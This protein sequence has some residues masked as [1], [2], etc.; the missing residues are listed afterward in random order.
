MKIEKYM[1]SNFGNWPVFFI[2]FSFRKIMDIAKTYMN[3]PI[4]IDSTAN[5]AL[6]LKKIIDEKKSRLL[7]TKDGK[8][9][10]I[11]S[12]KDLGLF[13]FS[14]NTER[15]LDQI[16]IA[17]VSK[18]IISVDE[19]TSLNKCAQKML[20]NGIGSLVITSQDNVVGLITKSDLVRYFASA[21]LQE[22]IVGEYMSPYYAWQYDDLSISKIV[23]KMI[24]EKISR[25]ILRDRYENPVGI[26][27]FRDLFNISLKLGE[28]ND[29]LDNSDP[30][31]S[32]IFP[33]KGFVSES[34]FG[35]NTKARE[36]MSKN[37]ISVKYDDDLAE[38][39][40]LLLNCNI[41]GG[42]VLSSSTLR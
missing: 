9:T 17:E 41:N 25:I 7:V 27:T 42:G 8:I 3:H 11:I 38:T 1:F 31:I 24:D 35:G 36:I 22:K 40:Q 20:E 34:G 37:I 16:P 2:I 19:N 23:L 13:L 39:G 10:E 26:I 15:K 18:K 12:E 4:T 6:V 14:D 33:R 5:L 29:I 28:E 21:H 32:I 30:L